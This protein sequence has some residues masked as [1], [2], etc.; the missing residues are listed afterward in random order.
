MHNLP[1]TTF[2]AQPSMHNLPCTTFHAQPSIHNLLPNNSALVPT[3]RSQLSSINRPRSTGDNSQQ[4]PD[5][6]RLHRPLILRSAAVAGKVFMLKVVPGNRQ[7]VSR[8]VFVQGE[9]KRIRNLRIRFAETSKKAVAGADKDGAGVTGRGG[10]TVERPA[11][12]P[13][14]P[15]KDGGDSR[16][17]RPT[18]MPPRRQMCSQAGRLTLP[19]E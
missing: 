2:H 1:C 11:V 13:R 14:D 4:T 9:L 12:A 7:E 17:G 16:A 10:S 3:V 18:T 5:N 6:R 15:A 19:L 8:P